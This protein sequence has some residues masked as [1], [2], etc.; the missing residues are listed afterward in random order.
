MRAGSA[1]VEIFQNTPLSEPPSYEIDLAKLP[2]ISFDAVGG[3]DRL[4]VDFA[5]GN[6]VPVGGGV[7]FLGG[8]DTAPSSPSGDV[9]QLVGTDNADAV[10]FNRDDLVLGAAKIAHSGV[11]SLLAAM[12]K[13]DDVFN[14]NAILPNTMRLDGGSGFDVLNINVGPFNF[15]SDAV[16]GSENLTINVNNGAIVNFGSTQ[17]LA[18]L[19]IGLGTV[20]M[21]P[22]GDKLLRTRG[23]T[24]GAGAALDVADNDVIVESTDLAKAALFAK[25]VDALK[26]GRNLGAW[27]GPGIRSSIAAANPG[28]NTGIGMLLNDKGGQPIMP[29]FSSEA[30]SAQCILLKYSYYGDLDLSGGVDADDYA[31]I[32]IGFANGLT[33]LPEGDID[34]SGGTPDADDYALIDIAFATQAEPL[35]TNGPTTPEQVR[36]TPVQPIRRARRKHHRRPARAAFVGRD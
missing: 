30:V 23:M 21:T 14:I 15:D 2:S 9:L 36:T 6:P 28:K 8:P 20:N 18:A 13:G 25:L 5:A 10:T 35:A 1:I 34:L 24:I 31:R 27:N 29:N 16:L 32:D 3:N 4:T 22:G 26:T 33:G 17:H 11:E 19:N 7:R 12:G